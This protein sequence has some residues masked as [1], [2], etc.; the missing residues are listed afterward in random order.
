MIACADLVPLGFAAAGGLF[1]ACAVLAVFVMRDER[2]LRRL[3]RRLK[4]DDD[5]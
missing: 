5:A 1:A 4:E 3:E 2:E